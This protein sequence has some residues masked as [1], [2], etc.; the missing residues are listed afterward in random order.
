[1]AKSNNDQ[2]GETVWKTLKEKPRSKYTTD[3]GPS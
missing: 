3:P 1:M 2:K